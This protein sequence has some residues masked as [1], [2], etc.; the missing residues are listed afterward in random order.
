MPRGRHAKGSETELHSVAMGQHHLQTD[1][2]RAHRHE[3]PNLRQNLE[4]Q[5]IMWTVGAAAPNVPVSHPPSCE[6]PSPFSVMVQVFVVFSNV[7][8]DVTDTVTSNPP[9][10]FDELP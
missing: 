3:R 1:G 8:C 4:S 9:T 6:L 7:P 2:E 10:G 5:T